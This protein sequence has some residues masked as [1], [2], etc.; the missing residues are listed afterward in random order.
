MAERSSLHEWINSTGVI[1]AVVISGIS[2]WYARDASL[3]KD[4]SIAITATRKYDDSDVLFSNG[5]YILWL[6]WTVT[7]ANKSNTKL[8]ITDGR[9][10]SVSPD[11]N[12]SRLLSYPER[13]SINWGKSGLPLVLDGGEAAQVF[14]YVPISM[15]KRF[16]DFMTPTFGKNF[17]HKMKWK[18]FDLFYS[19]FGATGNDD[20]I[21]SGKLKVAVASAPDQIWERGSTN[22]PFGIIWLWTGRGKTFSLEIHDW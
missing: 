5:G 4:E 2:L 7:I 8:A 14:A 11:G 6:P 3:S 21:Y 19:N 12:V 1:L 20:G 17:D 15:S 16:V 9:I 10:F 22:G 18:D 13:P